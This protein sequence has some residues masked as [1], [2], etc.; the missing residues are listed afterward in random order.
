MKLALLLDKM[1]TSDKISAMEQ[2]W[3]ELCRKP[4]DLPSSGWHNKIL[5]GRE[6]RVREGKANFSNLADT[7]DKVRKA[8][9]AS[10]LQR[11]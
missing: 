2:L 9:I 5:S 1:T 7:K 6:K 3:N 8:S 4:E 11:S 10:R